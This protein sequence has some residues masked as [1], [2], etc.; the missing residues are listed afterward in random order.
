[1][2]NITIDEIKNNYIVKLHK[3]NETVISEI[4][5][6]FIN[7]LKQAIYYMKENPEVRSYMAENAKRQSKKY[8]ETIYYKN[9]VEMIDEIVNENMENKN[10]N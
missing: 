7:N 5:F 9:F 8:D 10:G 2:S 6:S 3:A 4:P 1:M